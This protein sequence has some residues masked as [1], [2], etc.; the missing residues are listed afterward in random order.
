M[1]LNTLLSILPWVILILV[2]LAAIAIIVFLVFTEKVLKKK[3]VIK[4]Q[5]E[6]NSPQ[7]RIRLLISTKESPQN[8]LRKLNA[9]AKEIFRNYGFDSKL[10][11]Y[12][13]A[14]R[15]K[16]KGKKSSA[17]FCSEMFTIFYSGEE[18]DSKKIIDLAGLL[19]GIEQE[20]REEKN[21]R[22][23]EKNIKTSIKES[24]KVDLFQKLKKTENKIINKFAREER[25]EPLQEEISVGKSVNQ[26]PRP[27]PKTP[28]INYTTKRDKLKNLPLIRLFRFGTKRQEIQSEIKKS[29][30]KE[31]QKIPKTEVQTSKTDISTE[32]TKKQKS[33]YE[34]IENLKN[35]ILKRQK[36][37]ER[38]KTEQQIKKLENPKIEIE[39]NK[40]KSWPPV[41]FIPKHLNEIKKMSPE[42]EESFQEI[43]KEIGLLEDEIK[44]KQHKLKN[45]EQRPIQ[46]MAE[47]PVKK[48][49]FAIK[50]FLDKITRQDKNIDKEMSMKKKQID[51]IN[52]KKEPEYPNYSAPKVI[53]PRKKTIKAEPKNKTLKK[54][55]YIHNVDNM[56][57]IKN[58]IYM[59]RARLQN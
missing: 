3:V 8:K 14:D 16:E 19:L 17:K 20:F 33:K 22:N 23:I 15:F 7:R 2:S 49:S 35:E 57:R 27:L 25:I 11:Y 45:L 58:R 47:Y 56:D 59:R 43:N 10:S 52:V 39:I 53:A 38:L 42:I 31:I 55:E 26:R 51:L 24:P 48:P 32:E 5:K 30:E 50:K 37:I 44:S 21:L 36:Q 1:A 46:K 34:I 13:M 12:E 9:L 54:E 4:Q 18:L 41:T 28:Q 29:P 40:N 6:E